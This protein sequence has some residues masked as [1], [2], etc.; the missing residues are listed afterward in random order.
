MNDHI[1]PEYF[2]RRKRGDISPSK[3]ISF[4]LG[5]LRGFLLHIAKGARGPGIWCLKL[6]YTFIQHNII[7]SKTNLRSQL[8]T[9]DEALL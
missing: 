1:M 9:H 8:G 6:L 5:S 3:C 7:I 4:H 2:K